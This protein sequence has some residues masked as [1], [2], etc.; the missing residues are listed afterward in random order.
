MAGAKPKCPSCGVAGTEFITCNPGAVE[1]KGGD[2]WFEVAYCDECGHVY[3]VFAKITHKPTP[4]VPNFKP[5]HQ[6]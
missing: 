3:G 1:S 2:P 5:P 4:S 6:L